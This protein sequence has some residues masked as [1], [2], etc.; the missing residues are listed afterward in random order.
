MR[1]RDFSILIPLAIFIGHAAYLWGYTTDDAGISF[2]YARN[3][4]HGYG[5]VLNPG[6]APV[7]GYSNPLWTFLLAAAIFVGL[8]P[9]GAAK[10]M[11]II[12]SGATVVMLPVMARSLFGDRPILF[13]LFA[14]MALALSTPF[15][16]WSVGGLENSLAGFL[17]TA[18]LWRMAVELRRE[19]LP[20]SGIGFFLLA[21]TRPEGAIYIL[22]PFAV[23]LL[24]LLKTRQWRAFALWAAVFAVPLAGYHIWHY[25]YFGDL[26]P[27]TYYAKGRNIGWDQLVT[28]G[29]QGWD[30]VR[31]WT[32]DYWVYPAALSILIFLN[33]GKLVTGTLLTGSWVVGMLA[34]V[35]MGGDWMQEYRFISPLLPLVYLT[36]QEGMLEGF[37]FLSRF[38]PGRGVLWA[39]AVTGLMLLALWG[40]PALTRSPAV[41]IHP[42]VPLAKVLD[43]ALY[44][45]SLA[46]EAGVLRYATYADVDLGATSYFSGLRM[47]DLGGLADPVI[48]RA[49]YD[50]RV[51]RHYVLK[52]RRPTF[53]H[54][55][56][57]W[58]GRLG[59]LEGQEIW[60]D[61][62]L[63]DSY[64]DSEGRNFNF[65][66][67][68]LLLADRA[69]Q[70][71]WRLGNGEVE[72][73]GYDLS[74]DG[75]VYV[76]TPYWHAVKTPSRP[77]WL[78]WTLEVAGRQIGFGSR[79]ALYGWLPAER[80][81]IGEV[82]RERIELPPF[83]GEA[84]LSVAIV[85]DGVVSEVLRVP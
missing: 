12:F 74:T 19:G 49:R 70:H 23:R 52:V 45:R 14:P 39:T 6:D 24:G 81:K 61:Y 13:R 8:G 83:V 67:R 57:V 51:I 17:L 71:L 63:L 10:G 55:H 37:D 65:V 60:Q 31:S 84:K 9:I 30:Y 78:N 41:L 75:D 53:I 21:I 58:L 11:G 79:P 72:I 50:H 80:W 59:L 48:A 33:V 36:T 47:I 68:D 54:V 15:V 29:S 42:L 66:R 40:G 77:Y 43:R 27:N 7:E 46:E 35:Y 34:I 28:W 44:F 18:A 25:L 26:V 3:L 56:G 22:L 64:V 73:L 4:A 82:Y 1:G 20:L 16:L 69:P 5:L 62:V 38:I 2:T 76:F 32:G 85:G